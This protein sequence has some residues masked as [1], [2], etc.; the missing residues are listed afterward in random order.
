MVI[1][2]NAPVAYDYDYTS[3]VDAPLPEGVPDGRGFRLVRV[4]KPYD[5]YQVDRYLSGMYVAK[6]VG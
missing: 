3:P 2:T 6:E 1:L 4:L 5:T